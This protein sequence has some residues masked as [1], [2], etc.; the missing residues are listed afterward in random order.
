[1]AGLDGGRINIAACSLGGAQSA[2]DKSLAYMKSARPSG[3]RLDEFQ[4]LQFR[5]A[6]MGDRTGAARTFCV[7]RGGRTRPQGSGVDHVV[8]YGQAV[9]HDVGFEVANQAL[10][11]QAATATSANTASRKSCVICV[12]TRFSKAPTRSCADRLSRKLIEDAMTAAAVSDPKRLDRPREGSAGIIRLN[13]PKA[14]NAVTLEMFATRQGAR[15]LRNRSCRSRDRAGR[16]PVSGGLCAGGDIRAL[17]ESSKVRAI[18]ATSCGARNTSSTPA[19]PSFQTLYRLDGRHRMGGASGCPRMAPIAWRRNEQKLAMPEVGL[20]FFPDVGGTWLLS[21]RRA[22]SVPTFGLTGQTM[23]GPDAIYAHLPNAGRAVKQAGSFTRDADQSSP[24][25]PSGEIKTLIDSFAT[26]E[27]SGRSPASSRPSTV[28]SR[29]TGSKYRHRPSARRFRTGAGDADDA[30]RKIA[31]RMVV[32]LKAAAVGAGFVV[33]R[34]MPGAGISRRAGSVRQR[35]IFARRARRRDRQVASKMV[36][37]TDEDVTPAMV[38]PISPRSHRRIEVQLT[39]TE[40]SKR[41]KFEMHI[42]HSLASAIW[43]GR[44]R[45]IWSRP[46]TSDPFD[47]ARRRA[48]GE[49][50]G[51]DIAESSVASVKGA[52]SSSRCCPRAST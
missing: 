17:W 26:G 3:K 47:L 33:A 7:A 1:M 45:P 8:A 25:T 11:L 41:R 30:E 35:T 31:A 16:P 29:T 4:A 24:R 36:A 52:T 15:R 43:V 14:I 2:L 42:S 21:H 22:R 46:A 48:I 49:S 39:K 5:L 12:C 6:D 40:K 13:R 44:W 38:A 27:T 32:T 28:G 9:W 37:A 23:N 51:A 19:S 50:D 20:G 34:A 18:S 10:Q